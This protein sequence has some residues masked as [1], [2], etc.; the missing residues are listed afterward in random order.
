MAR[1][2]QCTVHAAGRGSGRR[3]AIRPA[4]TGKSY[5]FAMSRRSPIRPPPPRRARGGV[6]GLCALRLRHSVARE[7]R[8]RPRRGRE[9]GRATRAGHRAARGPLGRAAR[10]E[11]RRPADS[12]VGA[13]GASRRR[14][15][16]TSKG[17]A[18]AGT[19]TVAG[20]AIRDGRVLQRR[21]RGIAVGPRAA[22]AARSL[23]RVL[24]WRPV[25][26][27]MPP[28]GAPTRRCDTLPPVATRSPR[29]SPRSLVPR[30]G[31]L[32]RHASRPT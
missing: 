4:G 7:A 12:R 25:A 20:G 11:R 26:A 22:A 28:R 19:L 2:L 14:T 30:R 5:A 29:P 17:R 24:A 9:D 32:T 27:A 13:R 23:T 16:T 15:A 18:M 8:G 3:R 1:R 6:D 21:A 10:H 31:P